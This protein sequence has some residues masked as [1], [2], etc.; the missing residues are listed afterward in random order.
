[1]IK[2]IFDAS[3]TLDQAVGRL[4]LQRDVSLP[5]KLSWVYAHVTRDLMNGEISGEMK[6]AIQISSLRRMQRPMCL[7]RVGSCVSLR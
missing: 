1:M 7:L 4:E 3:R 5:S 6:R 2:D